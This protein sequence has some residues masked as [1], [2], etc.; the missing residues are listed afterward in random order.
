[1][2]E[3]FAATF[4]AVEPLLLQAHANV[5]YWK[6]AEHRFKPQP[7]EKY[8]ADMMDPFLSRKRAILHDERSDLDCDPA[9]EEPSLEGLP[10]ALKKWP[11]DAACTVDYEIEE[12]IRAK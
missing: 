3:V 2:L 10:S 12:L 8:L 11:I 6:Q 4:P 5:A 9:P 1:M 7:A